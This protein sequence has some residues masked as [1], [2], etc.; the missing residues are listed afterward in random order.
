MTIG[1]LPL[2]VSEDLE[3]DTNNSEKIE[4]TQTDHLNNRLLN[5]FLNKI[6][7]TLP[8]LNINDCTSE[9]CNSEIIENKQGS[10]YIISDL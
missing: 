5:A 10:V 9:D 4:I 1:K 2:K 7:D 6:N 3:I 8:N